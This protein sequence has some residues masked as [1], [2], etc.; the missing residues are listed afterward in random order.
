MSADPARLRG[1]DL[2]R[3]LTEHFDTT[4]SVIT[5]SDAELDILHP[6]SADDLI[7][8]QAFE[9]DERLPYWAD[10]WPSSLILAE[11]LAA[12]E[13]RGVRLLELGS[14]CGVVS[15]ACVKAGFD[16]TASDY[17]PEALLFARANVW[18]N[19]GEELRTRLVDWRAPPDDLGTF[20][21]IVASDVLYEEPYPA[22]VARLVASALN[23]PGFALIADPGRVHAPRFEDEAGRRGLAVA[24]DARLPFT[25]GTIR[26]YIDIFRVTRTTTPRRA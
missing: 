3:H 12:A 9:R 4:T 7:D 11:V 19:T 23:G 17:Y 20:D 15:T 25:A 1:A 18:Q 22:A 26:Q 24:R 14:G 2:V 5:L 21:M 6:R 16:V 8:E 10:V 13:G